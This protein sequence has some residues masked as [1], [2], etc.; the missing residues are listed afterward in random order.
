MFN[1][2][3]EFLFSIIFLLLIISL[4]ACQPETPSTMAA[5]TPTIIF[6]IQPAETQLAAGVTPVLTTNFAPEDLLGIWTRSDLDRGTLFLVFNESGTYFASHGSPDA[7]VHSGDYSLEGW[8]FTFKNGW[9]CED[10]P[11]VYAFRITGGGK[12][13]LLEPLNDNCPDRPAALKGYRWDRVEAT[14]TP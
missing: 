14:P 10:M 8:V 6:T 7:I 5:K 11:G 13:L 3:L 12:Y 1:G 9:D 2:N 4:S